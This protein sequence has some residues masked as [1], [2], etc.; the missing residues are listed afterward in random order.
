MTAPNRLSLKVRGY[1][2][3]AFI[4][5]ISTPW[6]SGSITCKHCAPEDTNMEFRCAV[7]VV[8]MGGDN[9]YTIYECA[10]CGRSW[11]ISRWVPEAPMEYE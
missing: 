6:L 7:T 8:G 5:D 9:V 2:T 1:K 3:S 11:A 4:V 10:N